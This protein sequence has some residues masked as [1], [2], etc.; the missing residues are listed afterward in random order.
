MAYYVVSGQGTH[1]ALLVCPVRGNG[2]ATHHAQ[3]RLQQSLFNLTASQELPREAHSRDGLH[4]VEVTR[5]D[6]MTNRSGV[7]GPCQDRGTGVAR[8]SHRRSSP[9]HGCSWGCWVFRILPR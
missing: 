8:I 3:T 5:V 2:T 6:E 4:S 1:S 7:D 9:N